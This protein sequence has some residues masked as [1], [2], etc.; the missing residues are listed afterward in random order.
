LRI[1]GGQSEIRNPQPEIKSFTKCKGIEVEKE[2]L[3]HVAEFSTELHEAGERYELQLANI[4]EQGLVDLGI[5]QQLAGDVQ[6][7][8]C[9]VEVVLVVGQQYVVE[10]V[11]S[12]LV[13]KSIEELKVLFLEEGD[14]DIVLG[15]MDEQVLCPLFVGNLAAT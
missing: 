13:A 6:G 3:R 5:V 10:Y 15:E 1:S 12:C 8:L 7:L 2:V 9:W 11:A 4:A 14:V